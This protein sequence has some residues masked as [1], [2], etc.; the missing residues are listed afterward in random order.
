MPGRTCK[1]H[2]NNDTVC[3]VYFGVYV[4]VCICVSQL[5]FFVTPG[6]QRQK[7]TQVK[8]KYELQYAGFGV[9]ELSRRRRWD[10]QRERERERNRARRHGLGT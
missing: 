4:F 5:S 1:P 9:D 2:K 10:K 6:R 3:F 8:G 7:T